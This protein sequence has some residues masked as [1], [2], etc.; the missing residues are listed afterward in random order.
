[1]SGQLPGYCYAGRLPARGA[2]NDLKRSAGK[3]RDGMH[4]GE[5]Q[6]AEG[7]AIFKAAGCKPWDRLKC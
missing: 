6:S 4:A 5:W 3:A 7:L 2:L 1:M